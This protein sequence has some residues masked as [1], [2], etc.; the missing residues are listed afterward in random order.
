[1]TLSPDTLVT[2]S[3]DLV[4]PPT[5]YT[6]LNDLLNMPNTSAEDISDIISKD[7]ALSARL[8]K[9]VNSPY[10]GFPSEITTISRAITIVGTRELVQLVLTTSVLNAFR[11][12]P[13]DLINM[14]EFWKHSL[15]C[16]LTSKLLAKRC[17]QSS[18]E[19]FFVLGLLHN[20]GSLIMYQS[21]P[22]M[23]RDALSSARAGKELLF[24]AEQR[25]LGFDHTEVGE[26]LI[27]KWRLPESMI[28][29]IRYHHSPSQAQQNHTEVAII[30][31]A[32]IMVTSVGELGNSG[33][34]H[35]PPIDPESWEKLNLDSD[36]LPDILE[37]VR[38]ELNTLVLALAA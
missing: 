8:L 9:I 14:D 11:G 28:E 5:T 22:E 2:K 13:N 24:E 33:D 37:Q 21:I 7:P 10:Y 34:D 32:D 3:L 36:L 17:K 19:H 27:R 6:Q 35:V 30:H 25:L 29:P 38:E 23:C 31:L 4:S 26:A 18:L 16:A 20:I 12:I 15:A 1:M